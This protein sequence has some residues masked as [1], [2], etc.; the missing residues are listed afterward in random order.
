[1]ERER[2]EV[3]RAE[4]AAVVDDGE[5]HL[6]NGGHAAQRL[7]RR[8][9]GAHIGQGVDVVHLRGGQRQGGRV[10]DEHAP[11]VAL[12][13][14]PAAHMVL[15]VVLQLDRA[16]IGG[17]AGAY[18]LVG[19]ALDRVFDVRRVVR[20]VGRAAHAHAG[21]CALFAVL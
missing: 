1:M 21:I 6:L 15:L 12:Q 17:F 19:R 10:L 11:A 7:I 3:A 8:V 14:R 18:V 20:H 2:A 16:G 9:I 4:A 5:L 13:E